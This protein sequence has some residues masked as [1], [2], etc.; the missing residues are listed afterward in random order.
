MSQPVSVFWLVSPGI[1][2]VLLHG[3]ITPLPV[4]TSWW[5][6]IFILIRGHAVPAVVILTLLF[7]SVANI[8]DIRSP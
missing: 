1:R 6:A 3:Y 8:G 2:F 7:D 4:I 5:S